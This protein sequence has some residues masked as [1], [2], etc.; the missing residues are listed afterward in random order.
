MK[1][2]TRYF[3]TLAAVLLFT[4]E[5]MANNTATV[6][7]QIDGAAAG[8]TDPGTVAYSNGTI[9]V[10]PSYGYYL[11][12]A[13]LT[14]VKTI[15][16]QHADARRRSPDIN[17]TVSVTATD[18]SADPS[19]VT[20]YTFSVTDTNYDYEITA[21]FHSRTD[22][23]GATVTVSAGS[24]TYN[25]SAQKPDVTVV[26]GAATLT[27]GTDFDVYY[28]DSINAGTGKI[29]IV[30]TRTYMGTKTGTQ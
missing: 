17:N 7:K 13:D 19:K 1:Q 30:G 28:A 22:I 18:A 10:T 4:S 11:T 6:I 21:N 20:T 8:T 25:G 15:D 9:T 2:I 29:T 27:K 26:L 16:S 12:A 24:Y 23:S 3:F 5:V 14:V